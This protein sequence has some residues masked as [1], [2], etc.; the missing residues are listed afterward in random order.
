MTHK[1]FIKTPVCVNMLGE[2][3]WKRTTVS[4]RHLFYCQE[5]AFLSRD[6]RVKSYHFRIQWHNWDIYFTTGKEFT[7]IE[8]GPWQT[9]I[10]KSSGTILCYFNE[11][12]VKIKYFKVIGYIS[13]W[14]SRNV[15]IQPWMRLTEILQGIETEI[16]YAK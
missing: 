15:I 8:I 11:K 10:V 12:I 7:Y 9:L 2:E 13:H 6:R 14:L 5:R 4:K 3:V 16:W 1:R